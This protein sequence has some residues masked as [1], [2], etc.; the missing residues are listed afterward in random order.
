MQVYLETSVTVWF[1]SIP[2]SRKLEG[3]ASD[4]VN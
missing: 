3:E 2:P 4:N 1:V